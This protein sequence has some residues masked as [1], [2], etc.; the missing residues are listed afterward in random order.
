[1]ADPAIVKRV[2]A[3]M[4]RAADPGATEEEQRTSA[5][6]AAKLC[7]EHGISIGELGEPAD[8]P[9]SSRA[10][11][12]VVIGNVRTVVE[13]VNAGVGF[14]VFGFATGLMQD[15][16]RDRMAAAAAAMR[17]PPP[18]RPRAVPRKPKKKPAR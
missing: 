9:T 14:D 1:M 11:A 4:A 16:I 17:T 5:H 6:I 13:A 7:R 10:R 2:R 15:V 3:L 18:A 12:E 8:E